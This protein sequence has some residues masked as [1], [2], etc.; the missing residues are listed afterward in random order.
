MPAIN[1]ITTISIIHVMLI[2]CYGY[3]CYFFN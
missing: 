2:K 3:L 1:N